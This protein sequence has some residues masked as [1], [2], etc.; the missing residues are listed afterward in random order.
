MKKDRNNTLLVFHDT[1]VHQSTTAGAA[2]SRSVMLVIRYQSLQDGLHDPPRDQ[3]GSKGPHRRDHHGNQGGQ[4][5]HQPS[6]GWASR[7]ACWCG[8][9]TRKL[10]IQLVHGQL[11]PIKLP[12]QSTTGKP[13]TSTVMCRFLTMVH[14]VF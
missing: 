5:L 11:A 14:S 1:I 9:P 8:P 6:P 12:R 7:A 13:C 2:C 4:L 10:F 3:H